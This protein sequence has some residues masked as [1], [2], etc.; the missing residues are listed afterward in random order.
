MSE[1]KEEI[2]KKIICEEKENIKKNM[3]Q[4]YKH[5]LTVYVNN[6]NKKTKDSFSLTETTTSFE[7]QLKSNSFSDDEVAMYS[8]IIENELKAYEDALVTELIAQLESKLLL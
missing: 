5:L 1:H 2:V 6:L 4:N 3:I 7:R 8:H